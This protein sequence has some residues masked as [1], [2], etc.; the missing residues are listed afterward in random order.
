MSDHELDNDDVEYLNAMDDLNEP[1][2]PSDEEPVN[3]RPLPHKV[4]VPDE[5]QKSIHEVVPKANALAVDV[6]RPAKANLGIGFQLHILV[7]RNNSPVEVS[8]IYA[9]EVSDEELVLC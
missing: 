4:R 1:E 8:S 5:W 9:A 2:I 7:L 3:F 6:A